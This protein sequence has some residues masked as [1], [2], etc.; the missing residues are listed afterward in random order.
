MSI[1]VEDNLLTS[2]ILYPN[3]NPC[4][5][6]PENRKN[7]ALPA[8]LR[9]P[10]VT[11]GSLKAEMAWRPTLSFRSSTPQPAPVRRPV[12][13]MKGRLRARR[14]DPNVHLCFALTRRQLHC[15]ER[16]Q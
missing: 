13:S 3:A 11:V 7:P 1:R 12:E 8:C 15:D 10:Y 2:S 5:K 6:N 14:G 9:L 16:L 4:L